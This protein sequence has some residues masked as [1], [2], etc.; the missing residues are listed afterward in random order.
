MCETLKRLF[1]TEKI[2]ER[3][4]NN[5]VLRGWI[6]ARQAEEILEIKKENN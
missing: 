3:A 1:L 4:L 2:T 6:T 5:A